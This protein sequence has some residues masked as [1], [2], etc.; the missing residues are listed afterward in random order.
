[1]DVL[2]ATTFTLTPSV[3]VPFAI[4]FFGLGVGYFVWGGQLFFGYPAPG[5]DEGVR[6]MERS[7]GLWGIWMPGFMQFIAGITTLIGLTWFNVFGTGSAA[8]HTAAYAAALAFT[9]YG[10]HWFSMGMRRYIQGDVMPDGWMAIPFFVIS[11]L[12]IYI[13]AWWKD[14]PVEIVFVLLALIY[15]SETLVRFGIPIPLGA[16]MVALWQL[17]N[18]VWLMYMTWAVTIDL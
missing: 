6:H 7:I 3:Y 15:L 11:C 1:M 10:V 12:G 13:F 17:L 8:T 18:G 5:S 2:A 9:A 14:W 4:G 16:R